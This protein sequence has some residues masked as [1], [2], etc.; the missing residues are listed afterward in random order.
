MH[1]YNVAGIVL[2]VFNER[3]AATHPMTSLDLIGDVPFFVVN[4]LAFPECS[5]QAVV[6]LILHFAARISAHFDFNVLYQLAPLWRQNFEVV[7]S[8]NWVF[9]C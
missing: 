1:S 7:V 6:V 4:Y 5:V 3:W 2:T 8:L 9:E